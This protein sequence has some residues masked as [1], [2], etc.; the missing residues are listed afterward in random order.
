M[1]VTILGTGTAAPRP[2]RACAGLLVESGA[3]RLLLDCGPGTVERLA[4]VGGWESLTHVLLSHFHNDHTGDLP[5]LLF[6]LR[7]GAPHRRS[8]PLELAGPHG[9]RDRLH[10]MAAAFGS[11]VVEPGFPLR[12]QELAPA[13]E[14]ATASVRV[15]CAAARHTPGAL[16]FRVRSAA[17]ELGYTGDTG[18]DDAVADFLAGV[19]VL[20]AECSLPDEIAMD[21]HLSPS[22]VAALARRAAPRELVLTHMYPQVDRHTVCDQVRAA[23][24]AGMTR[25]AEDGLRIAVGS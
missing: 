9:L 20:V 14:I 18:P 2:D 13:D 21:T 12:L 8:E 1:H 15:S 16:C 6:A 5:F 23:G 11:H 17:G 24:W 4:R 19:D 10:A 22:S 3:T 25:V 7:W